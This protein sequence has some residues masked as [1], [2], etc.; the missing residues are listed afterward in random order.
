[1]KKEEDKNQHP[2]E[3]LADKLDE[4]QKADPK[5]PHMVCLKKLAG[6]LREGQVQTAKNVYEEECDAIKKYPEVR[7]TIEKELFKEIS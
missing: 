6:H 2:L 4:I 5:A 1:M 3:K 7:E